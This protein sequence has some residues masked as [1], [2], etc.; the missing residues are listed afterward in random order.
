M[1]N[2]HTTAPETDRRDRSGLGRET[3]EVA[4]EIRNKGAEQVRAVRQQAVRTG[5][6]AADAQKEQ[7]ADQVGVVGAAL[8][9]AAHRVEEEGPGGVGQYME[10]V[11]EE[12]EGVSEYLRSRSF[13]EL[14]RDASDFAR[15]NPEIVLGGMF[16]AGMAI[17]RFLKSSAEAMEEFDDA[18]DEDDG[19][20]A[21]GELGPD[22]EVPE[23][24]LDQQDAPLSGSEP[25]SA[26]PGGADAA[27]V[28]RAYE[29]PAA[30]VAGP[31]GNSPAQP[32]A[33]I[34]ESPQEDP[35]R[36]QEERQ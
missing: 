33:D 32:A 18:Y 3:R 17:S 19:A 14:Y 28:P 8:R 35:L 6:E 21:S 24:S 29:P 16:L 27:D 4:D 11:A 20:A 34:H 25:P 5:Q 22:D 7:A 13:S 36:E 30:A 2:A 10:V 1:S 31:E 9:D 26:I 12:I 23:S 15:S